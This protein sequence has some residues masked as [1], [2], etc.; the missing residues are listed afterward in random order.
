MQ[1]SPATH[2]LRTKQ[3]VDLVASVPDIAY[4]RA[5]NLARE[6]VQRIKADPRCGD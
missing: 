2:Q 6:T 5:L 4:C 3:C 1:E